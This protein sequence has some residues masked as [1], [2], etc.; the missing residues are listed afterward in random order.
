V[1][2][3]PSTLSET[4]LLAKPKFRKLPLKHS[5]FTFIYTLKHC[6][7]YRSSQVYGNDGSWWNGWHRT[8]RTRRLKF[9]NSFLYNIQDLYL[10]HGQH[11]LNIWLQL[12]LCRYLYQIVNPGVQN[13]DIYILVDSFRRFV[14]IRRRKFR[15]VDFLSSNEFLCN[16]LFTVY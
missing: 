11:N 8:G 13:N 10:R 15:K 1:I 9:I 7:S 12:C 3:I 4:I 5:F 14:W 6:T 16:P 2:L